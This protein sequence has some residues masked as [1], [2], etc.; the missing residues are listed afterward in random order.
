M[1]VCTVSMYESIYVCVFLFHFFQKLELLIH[2]KYSSKVA[3]DVSNYK[4]FFLFGDFDL[5]LHSSIH[6]YILHIHTQIHLY[7]QVLKPYTTSIYI[8]ILAY[9]HNYLHIYIHTYMHTY[10]HAFFHAYVRKNVFLTNRR[11]ESSSRSTMPVSQ[12][13]SLTQTSPRW[14]RSS[15]WSGSRKMTIPQMR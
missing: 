6:T 3:A 11:N 14:T 13:R 8:D 4:V 2:W 10:V 12:A 9:I 15:T 7:I 1:Y 5:T